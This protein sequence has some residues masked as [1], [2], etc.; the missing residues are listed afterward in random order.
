MAEGGGM[1]GAA[2]VV[3]VETW[4]TVAAKVVGVV[5]ETAAK[6]VGVV[7]ETAAK[8]VGVVVET[9]AKVVGVVGVVAGIGSDVAAPKGPVARKAG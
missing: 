1:L 5:V 7:V 3:V 6:V 4:V 2:K 9:A 8:V